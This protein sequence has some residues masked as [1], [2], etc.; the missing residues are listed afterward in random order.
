SRLPAPPQRRP[1]ACGVRLGAAPVCNGRMSI[2]TRAPSRSA[3]R[4]PGQCG[5]TAAARNPS[6]VNPPPANAQRVGLRIVDAP[7]RATRREGHYTGG[8][9]ARLVRGVPVFAS[10][11]LSQRPRHYL[12]ADEIGLGKTL[13]ALLA[14]AEPVW[15]GSWWSV[16]RD[17]K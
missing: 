11:G 10:P 14:V 9:C 6:A 4:S 12:G 15:P 1:L 16:R 17:R 8:R 3:A 5:A 13:T 2:S 7:G